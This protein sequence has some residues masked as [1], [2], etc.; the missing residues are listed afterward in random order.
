MTVPQ[1]F[2]SFAARAAIMLGMAAC[3]LQA[4]AADAP[5]PELALSFQPKH[6]GVDVET[7]AKNQLPN[8][9]VT[10]ER[11]GKLS[12]WI[13]VGPEG[14][15]LRR[16]V[17]TNEDNVVDNWRYYNRGLEV[18]RD[19]DSNNNGK[20][21]Q[22][23]WLNS[24]G[25]RWGI[26]RN[27][28]GTI[29]EWRM[30]SPEEASK[31]AVEAIVAGD[32]AALQTVLISP[33]EL[34]T[35]GIAEELAVEIKRS[36]S[37]AA[38]KM[39]AAAGNSKVIGPTTKWMRFDSAVPGL[40]PAD[41]GKSKRDLL[42][43]ENAM[44]IVETNGE[45][46]LVQVGEMIRIGEV[47]KLTQI[48]EPLGSGAVQVIAGG[49]LMQPSATA[50]GGDPA[51]E[52]LSDNVRALLEQLQKL[53]AASPTPN[54][55]PEKFASYNVQR[56]KILQGL[57]AAADTTAEKEQ[58]TAQVA[59]SLA[60]AVQA[61]QYSQGLEQL[62]RLE[63]QTRSL[64]EE[65]SILPYVMYRRLLSEYSER[66]RGTDSEERTAVQKWW[67]GELKQFAEKYPEA[68]D[69]TEALMQLAISKEF[70]GEMA[71]ANAY[72]AKLAKAF[73]DS[74]AGQR[75][76]GAVRRLGL[77]GQVLP[78]S[79]PSLGGGNIDLASFRGKAVLILFWSTWCKPCAEDLPQIMDLYAKFR[80]RGFEIIGV[81][82]D[83]SPEPVAEYL[84]QKGIRWPQVYERGG[85]DGGP[86]LDL[87]IV[88]LPTMILVG[89]DGKVVSRN[90]SVDDLREA[91]PEV[92]K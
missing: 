60:A 52:G 34:K 8:C 20:I 28:D 36:V 64:S 45:P 40:I 80:G 55:S 66:L 9:K 59:D 73:P 74:P 15:V 46:G 83:D 43:Y 48:P 38:G 1:V 68:D 19:I 21:D 7:P 85:F 77:K 72:Y 10:V 61:G 11:S 4:G 44:A 3:G 86:A 90:I 23:R 54:D 89:P 22:F 13:V 81:A 5:T 37:N 27:E 53:D 29:D 51:P 39:R 42:V 26:D 87:G 70:A 82:L 63:Q 56:A 91:L 79:G 65:S 78:F 76:R 12:G 35:L 16:F 47:W 2:P 31:V 6:R 17:D 49:I 71:E 50:V 18:Y 62:R 41:E 84:R 32:A 24:G 25:T 30:L 75:A 69:T 14:Q 88:S 58:W 67:L 33:E 92:L 57:V